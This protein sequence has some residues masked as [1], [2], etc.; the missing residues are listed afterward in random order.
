M[1]R[2]MVLAL[3]AAA[4]IVLVPHAWAKGPVVIC[5]ATGC[6]P[7]GDELSI[8]RWLPGYY[9]RTDR[10]APAVPSSY[11]VIRFADY[12]GTLAYWT[13]EAGVLRVGETTIVWARPHPDDLTALQKATVGLEPYA[14][15]RA[16]R[17]AV[18]ADP[19]KPVEMRS[20]RGG[21]TYLRLYSLGQP[22]AR[23]N[24]ARTWLQIWVMGA[25]TPWTDGQNSL[26]ISR[27]G[28]LLLRD[29]T[30][31]RIPISIADQI[32]KRV[33]LTLVST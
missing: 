11:F 9:A 27:R 24:G 28:A 2:V 33:P 19:G 23:A 25:P 1:R 4:A 31:V 16:A 17:A 26:W 18:D 13:P 15:P 14:A 22:V 32:R 30:I 12:G 21:A 5:G 29:G 10:V 7:L 8:R 20:V 6:A 3:V